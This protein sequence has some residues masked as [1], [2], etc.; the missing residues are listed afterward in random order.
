[1]RKQISA[2]LIIFLSFL[3]F[4]FFRMYWKNSV[5]SWRTVLCAKKAIGSLEILSCLFVEMF[6]KFTTRNQSLLVRI[7]WRSCDWV[8]IAS[9]CLVDNSHLFCYRIGRFAVFSLGAVQEHRCSRQSQ[10]L[11]C[12]VH[13]A[14]QC[15]GKYS[16][17]A[18][19][20]CWVLQSLMIIAP[21]SNLEHKIWS[22][23][24]AMNL[25][26][27]QQISIGRFQRCSMKH[28]KSKSRT[29]KDLSTSQD[30]RAFQGCCQWSNWTRQFSS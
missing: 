9:T 15:E 21:H 8:V 11:L 27:T 6:F 12:N 2:Q 7:S 28:L 20:D 24:I 25:K 14:V 4:S 16:A 18:T 1:M 10:I 23:W 29:N 17:S 30:R 22:P 3:S 5:F 13:L 19:C 26:Q